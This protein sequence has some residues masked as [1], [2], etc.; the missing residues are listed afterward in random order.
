MTLYDA[1][2]DPPGI[3][4][5]RRP[6][7]APLWLTML[8]VLV[9]G[10]VAIT[11]YRNANTSV[12]LLTRPAEK[13]PGTISDPPLS[14]EGEERAQQLA[15]ML[16][17]SGGGATLDGIYVSDDRRSQQTAAPLAQRLHRTPVVFKAGEARELASRVLREHPGGT[18]LVITSGATLTDIIHELGGAEPESAP[19][20]GVPTWCD[21]ATDFSRCRRGARRRH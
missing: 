9:V 8:A 15:Q 18:V 17:D 4:R 6:F 1:I 10:G 3:T 11:L 12:V 19:A 20:L 13:D 2:M 7:F 5:H 14:A 21:C 16:G